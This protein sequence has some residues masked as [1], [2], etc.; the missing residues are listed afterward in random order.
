MT[1]G[2]MMFR[3]S[4]G[5]NNRQSFGFSRGR[6]G[7]VCGNADERRDGERSSTIRTSLYFW[8]GE[9]RGMR[10]AEGPQDWCILSLE[11][12]PRVLRLSRSPSWLFSRFFRPFPGPFRA[13]SL[14]HHPSH[15]TSSVSSVY[16]RIFKDDCRTILRSTLWAR[17][18][19]ARLLFKCRL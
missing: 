11:L 3:W 19:R 6:S 5:G 16:G 8:T 15:T 10:E 13:C 18:E 14:D 9:C 2:G 1:G 12:S 7:R 17:L 4:A